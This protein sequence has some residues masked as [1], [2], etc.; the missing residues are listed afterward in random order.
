MP[1]DQNIV[2]GCTSL[3][4]A[5]CHRFTFPPWGG[6]ELSDV[7]HFRAQ[8]PHET[9]ARSRPSIAGTSLRSSWAG[10]PGARG[11]SCLPAA[12]KYPVL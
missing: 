6:E 11:L 8:A 1:G 12:G 4:P 3:G 10:R 7:P 5:R 2:P 9:S